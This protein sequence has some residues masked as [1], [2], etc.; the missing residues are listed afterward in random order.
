MN[1]GNKLCVPSL[2]RICLNF[3]LTHAAGRPIKAMR[4]AELFEE[5]E[6]Y[7]EA[8]RFVLD[9]PGGWPEQELNTLSSET[10]LKL[11]KRYVCTFSQL[12]DSLN[13]WQTDVVPRTRP[14]TRPRTD[15]QRIRMCTLRYL[16]SFRGLKSD[17]FFKRR[18]AT[19]SVH[20]AQI[21]RPAH[22]C[23]TKSGGRLIRPYS[24][25][26]H[27]SPRWYSGTSARSKASVPHLRSRTSCARRP[28]KRSSLPV[29][30]PNKQNSVSC[31]F[32]C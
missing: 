3:L 18:Y 16:P 20:P 13:Y 7:R 19:L 32:F 22:A 14:Q 25:S 10:L 4:I 12:D 23:S 26:V 11:E 27:A 9:N 2:Q 8:S 21:R 5:E 1:I 6:L 24:A 17:H 31:S 15:R 29:R 28:P 30:L